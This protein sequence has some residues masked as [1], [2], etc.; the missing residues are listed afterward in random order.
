MSPEVI[1]RQA[2]DAKVD[3]WALG[4]LLYQ[5]LVGDVPFDGRTNQEVTSNVLDKELTIPDGLS[6]E[7]SDLIK[8]LLTK[9]P[10]KRISLSEL[11]QH[12]WMQADKFSS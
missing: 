9:D 10:S 5:F 3:V 12:P 2:Y 8:K 1:L 7:A 6:E 4:I 11:I